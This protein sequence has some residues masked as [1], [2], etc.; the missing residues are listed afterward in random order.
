MIHGS[1]IPKKLFLSHPHKHKK[2]NLFEFKIIF[3]SA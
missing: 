3:I 1:H 2:N